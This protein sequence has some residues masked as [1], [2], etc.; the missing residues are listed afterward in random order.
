MT[1]S[2]EPLEGPC[3]CESFAKV[4]QLDSD[5]GSGPTSTWGVG[6]ALAQAADTAAALALPQQVRSSQ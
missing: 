2:V 3:R 1:N 5:C 4:D 6:V